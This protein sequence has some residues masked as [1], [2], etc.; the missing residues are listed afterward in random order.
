MFRQFWDISI[1][2]KARDPELNCL[3]GLLDHPVR[4]VRY[5]AAAQ[6]KNIDR[7]VFKKI[8]A[9][10]GKSHDRVGFEAR[11]YL[12]RVIG[13]EKAGKDTYPDPVVTPQLS[14]QSAEAA[15]QPRHPPPAAMSLAQIRRQLS[16]TMRPE[17]AARVLSLARPAVGLWPQS[18]IGELPVT[19]SRLGGRCP[20]YLIDGC[21]LLRMW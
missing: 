12:D 8:L 7:A 17:F 6:F 10:L 9:D 16:Q 15:W 20:R 19:A 3:R 11:S 5:D 1:E 18:P 21:T 2:L 13:D 14:D 4:E